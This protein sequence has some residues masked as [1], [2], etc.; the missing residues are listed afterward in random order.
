M[1]HIPFVGSV[2]DDRLYDT[3]YD[4]WVQQV[5]DEVLVG[6]SSFGIHL[7]GKIIAFTPKPKGVTIERGRGLG[8][9]ECAK[10]VLAVHA[11]L[12]LTL[13]EGNETLEEKPGLL[14]ADPYAAWMV[15]GKALCWSAEQRFW[16]NAAAYRQH[17]LSLEPEAT[18]S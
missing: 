16:V 11:P 6:A 13:T 5:G 14:N 9:V 1:P 17:I 4:M 12:S 8:T 18:L 2:P 10:T 3:T 15:R 7:A